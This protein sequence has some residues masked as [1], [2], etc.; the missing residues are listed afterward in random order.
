MW[1]LSTPAKGNDFLWNPAIF[2]QNAKAMLFGVLAK[3]YKIHK[4]T[5]YPFKQLVENLCVQANV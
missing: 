5:I 1:T 4:K 2:S 3:N